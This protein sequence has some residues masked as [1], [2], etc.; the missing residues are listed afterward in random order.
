MSGSRRVWIAG[1]A[2][3]LL[4]LLPFGNFV[5]TNYKDG[6]FVSVNFIWFFLQTTPLVIAAVVVLAGLLYLFTSRHA[7]H[8][9]SRAV[10]TAGGAFFLLFF[11][12]YPYLGLFPE[13]A[14]EW[15]PAGSYLVLIALFAALLFTLAKHSAVLVAALLFATAN[16]ALTLPSIVK[17]TVEAARMVSFR[18][19]PF[20]EPIAATTGSRPN[21]YYFIL[22]AYGS[23]SS[24]RQTLDYDNGPFI[25]AMEERGFYH[26]GDAI[27]SYNRTVFT[28]ASIFA[29]D[30]FVTDGMTVE[31]G[32]KRHLTYPSLLNA[33]Y[34]PSLVVD[35]K[36]QG[37]E[38]YLVGNYWAPCAG[39]W[40][41]CYAEAQ[42][43]AYLADVFWSAT[44][45]MAFVA[46]ARA[47]DAEN[48]PDVDAIGKLRERLKESGAPKTPTFTFV[49]HLSPHA[50]YLFHADCSLRGEYG[51][52]LDGW[53][54]SAKPYFLDN[55][56]CANLNAAQI[57]DEIIA[58]DPDSI[59][60][61]QG[62]HGTSFTVGW[63]RPFDEWLP[64]WI[65]ER[66][67]MLNLVRLPEACRSWLAPDL[68]N[69]TTIQ[70]VMGCVSGREP[71]LNS[72]R[73]YVTTFSKESP[74]HGKVRRIDPKTFRAVP[75]AVRD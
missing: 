66:S 64:A 54:E 2:A 19:T 44:P 9:L 33:P 12:H 74:D 59:V 17:T 70:A 46:A 20:P 18:N 36:S 48:V 15:V 56:L 26:A 43:S 31:E 1:A 14:A 55:L 42:G 7:A 30:Y 13:G 22:D 27:S 24:I 53:P 29:Q 58:L 51:I 41:S 34:P 38:F 32:K 61:F 40:V 3:F 52:D 11:Y 69:V 4:V 75:E 8:A 63:D 28:L 10:L 67:S 62:D 5:K 21:V 65:H 50:P 23:V 25:E 72:P 60:V 6:S 47:G 35:A 37:Y 71:M 49:H 73:G 16:L 45:S 39:P 68:D 57:A